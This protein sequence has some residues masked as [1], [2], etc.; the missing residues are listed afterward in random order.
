M[1]SLAQEYELSPDIPKTA[2]DWE[3]IKPPVIEGL[4][5]FLAKT[6]SLT[7]YGVEVNG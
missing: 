6:K 3:N 4:D 5:D 2:V 1:S 7:T